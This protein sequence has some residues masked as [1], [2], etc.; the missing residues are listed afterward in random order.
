MFF[1]KKII[2]LFINSFFYFIFN[3][4]NFL[5]HINITI[6]SSINIILYILKNAIHYICCISIYLFKK[7]HSLYMLYIY[8]PN[9]SQGERQFASFIQLNSLNKFFKIIRKV[10]RTFTLIYLLCFEYLSI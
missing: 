9:T 2:F 5:L 3:K 6:S 8:L 10:I 1:I 4:Y 7:C